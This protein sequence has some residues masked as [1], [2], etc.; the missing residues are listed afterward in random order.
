MGK[1]RT[2][3]NVM[4]SCDEGLVLKTS[5]LIVSIAENMPEYE[6]HFY[7]VHGGIG[8][9]RISVLEKLSETYDNIEF[10]EIKIEDN[11]IYEELASYGGKWP[12]AAYYSICAHLILP[13]DIDRIMYLDAGDTLVLKPPV[14]YYF[15]DFEGKVMTVTVSTGDT[16]GRIPSYNEDDLFDMEKLPWIVRGLFNSG[17]Y[18]INLV[19]MREIGFGLNDYLML[20]RTLAEVRG[21]DKDVYFGDQGFLSAAYIGNLKVYGADHDR[22]IWY[23]P[24]DLCT[25]YFFE[26]K[27]EPDYTFNI[28][29]FS[30]SEKP[31]MFE[32]P[33]GFDYDRDIEKMKLSPGT[34]E[35]YRYVCLWRSYS[36]QAEERVGCS[37]GF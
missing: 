6:N 5:P 20:A 23:M 8:R 19:K 10:H 3:F 4:T 11:S 28:I 33:D 29:H 16:D 22:G 25:P 30:T 12:A 21:M 37:F 2:R 31:W 14:D 7:L 9:D 36:R 18:V 15:G 24:N 13:E 1:V 35:F 17:S 27:G 34:K 32:V 26:F